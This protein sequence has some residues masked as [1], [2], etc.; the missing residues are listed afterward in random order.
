MATVPI[1]SS[2]EIRLILIKFK[3]FFLELL[4]F[5]QKDPNFINYH[6]LQ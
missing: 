5:T 1:I 3:N 2:F 4:F 6:F